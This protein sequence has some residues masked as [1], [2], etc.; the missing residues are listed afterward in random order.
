MH[1]QKN[2]PLRC[3][4]I[5]LLFALIVIP[6]N[7]DAADPAMS[8]FV[9][10]GKDGSA[11]LGGLAGADAQCQALAKSVGSSFKSWR[12]YL[13][14]SA[15]AG[16]PSVDA[17]NRIGTG[18]WFN[19]RGALIARNLTELHSDLHHID[20]STALD[21]R[22]ER[23]V[24][25][26]DILTGS[27][28][29]G[30]LAMINDQPATCANWTSASEGAARIG[31]DDRM[32]ANSHDN[33]RF[34]RYNGSWNSEHG[35]ASENDNAGCT[36]MRLK[37]YGGAGGFYCFAAD[38]QAFSA[39]RK[40]LDQQRYTFQRGVNINHWL[41]DN[42]APN[43]GNIGRPYG[44]TWFDQDDVAWI[45]A[46]GFD[47]LRVWVGGHHWIKPD[48][49][50]DAE[51]IAHFDNTLRWAQQHALGVVLA[52]H[53]TPGYR[54]AIRYG[55]PPVDVSSPF[56]DA[57]TRDDAAYLWWLIAKRYA[58]IGTQLRFELIL[59]P[60]APNRESLREFNTAALAAIRKIDRDRMV[61]L[62]PRGSRVENLA[63]VELS[64]SNTALSLRFREPEIFALQ[65]EPDRFNLTFPGKVPDLINR[66]EPTE[67]AWM[68]YS[69]AE[70]NEENLTS[71]IDEYFRKVQEL[72]RTR[73]HEIYFGAIGVM[74][75]VDD[76]STKNYL[77]AL[78][79]A[80]ER[81]GIAWAVYDYNTG[82]A[83]RSDNGEGGP[84]RMIEGLGLR[85]ATNKK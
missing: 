15:E 69:K 33:K 47:H 32:D 30:R 53:S 24:R 2:I 1:L 21:E 61:Y 62:T 59:S 51:K 28:S 36:A 9:A 17:R 40:P 20:Q 6:L 27:T 3:L 38:A 64:D 5:G 42:I 37:E 57:T 70:L 10:R 65:F 23:T 60:D 18:P 66:L 58:D 35:T 81:K 80:L 82:G 74:L 76:A 73:K 49:K 63:D 12:A 26:H 77:H 44:A 34:V 52:M 54:A 84:T 39:S 83:V 68:R 56:T 16:K 79:P 48:G 31:H 19:A 85:T 72:D 25:A 14:V 11:N 7:I 75:G 43:D 45:A 67:A 46:H 13:S 55:T 78:R 22:G 50:I 41:G 4:L 8:F 71:V 29:E